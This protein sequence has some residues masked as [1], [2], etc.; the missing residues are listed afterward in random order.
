MF[1]S[2]PID[3]RQ[4]IWKLSFQEKIFQWT[5]FPFLVWFLLYALSNNDLLQQKASDFLVYF[6]LFCS[7]QKFLDAKTPALTDWTFRHLRK[8]G[9]N[10][11]FLVYNFIL[12]KLNEKLPRVVA[13]MTLVAKKGYSQN[14]FTRKKGY[15]RKWLTDLFFFKKNKAP[16]FSKT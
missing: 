10:F 8:W 7:S 9:Q 15:S 14:Y 12:P 5:L 11:N 4:S 6:E 1:E 16:K 13:K 2:S 3:A